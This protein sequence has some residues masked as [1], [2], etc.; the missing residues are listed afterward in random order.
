[1]SR[2]LAICIAILLLAVFLTGGVTAA[3][4]T[5]QAAITTNIFNVMLI[6]IFLLIFFSLRFVN[7]FVFTAK[8]S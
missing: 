5:G 8:R 2:N 6:S 4:F 7:C 1:M 3:W